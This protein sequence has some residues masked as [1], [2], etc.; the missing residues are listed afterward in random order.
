MSAKEKMIQIPVSLFLRITR[1]FEVG[2]GSEDTSDDADKI[3]KQ[4]RDKRE[5][6]R[7]HSLYS[8]SKD[9]TL[10][11]EEREAARQ[12]YL[13]LAGISNDFRW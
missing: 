1:Y 6:Y 9:Q 12:E 8:K 11:A 10:S 5:A 4:I 3:R 13:N 7:K 2:K